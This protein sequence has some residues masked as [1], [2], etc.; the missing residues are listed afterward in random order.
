MITDKIEI[1][2]YDTPWEVACMLITAEWKC[3]TV[4]VGK[5]KRP[6]FDLPD[7]RRIGKHII[8]YCNT[9]R[10]GGDER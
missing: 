4:L 1:T 5:E 2:P 7:L 3:T 10:E 9:E 6:F 8:N